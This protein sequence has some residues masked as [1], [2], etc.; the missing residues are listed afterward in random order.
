MMSWKPNEFEQKL[1]EKIEE[2]KNYC[3]GELELDLFENDMFGDGWYAMDY[4]EDLECAFSINSTKFDKPL[5]TEETAQ[6]YNVDVRE[7]C[8]YCNVYYVG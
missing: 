3:K 4:R 2:A 5:I 7:C 8:D 1:I 6:K